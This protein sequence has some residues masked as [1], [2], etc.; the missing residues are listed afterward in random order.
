MRSVLTVFPSKSH[1]IAPSLSAIMV[2]I[3][4][5]SWGIPCQIHIQCY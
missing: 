5:G 3:W 1:R 4:S 2:R